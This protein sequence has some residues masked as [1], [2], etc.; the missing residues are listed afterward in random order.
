MEKL[1]VIFGSRRSD[2]KVLA[3]SGVIELLNGVLGKGVWSVSFLS[4]HRHPDELREY[5]K[6]R[7]A[8]GTRVFIGA[9]GKKCD[10]PGAIAA[11][12]GPLATV[13]GVPLTSDSHSR[14]KALLDLTDFPP[15]IEVAVVGDGKDGLLHAAV[16][17]CRI[18]SQTDDRVGERLIAW[19][20]KAAAGREPETDVNI[21][22]I[23]GGL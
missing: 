4:A 14:D 10:L 19:Q 1:A 11:H 12:A 16:F 7:V 8:E 13:I 5:V 22:E 20:K 6:A 15:G 17:A 2:S 18:I 3:A 21:T 9:A 23:Q